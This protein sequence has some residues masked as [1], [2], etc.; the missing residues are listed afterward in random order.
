MERQKGEDCCY[1]RVLI[2]LFSILLTCMIIYN[3]FVIEPKGNIT[4]ELIVLILI[5]LVI[6]LSEAFDQFAIGKLLSFSREADKKEKQVQR[7]EQD[8]QMLLSQL[9]NISSLQNQNQN[10][11]SV[12]GDYHEGSQAKIDDSTDESSNPTG[13]TPSK[14]K[15]KT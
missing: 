8:K 11:I 14:S 5:L 3:F 12:S 2:A 4:L 10:Q 7:L 1:L 13:F 6:V 15:E 9:I